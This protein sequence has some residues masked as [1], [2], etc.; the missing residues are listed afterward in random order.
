M[1]NRQINAFLLA[2]VLIPFSSLGEVLGEVKDEFHHPA[3]QGRTI[4][5]GGALAF[6]PQAFALGI[7]YSEP[8]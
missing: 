1:R 5:I 7:V 2:L 6:D 4:A 8:I 3:Y